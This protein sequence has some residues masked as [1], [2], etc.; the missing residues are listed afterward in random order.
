[1]KKD[2]TEKDVEAI[3]DGI[4]K[5]RV[6]VL[7]KHDA[8]RKKNK[9]KLSIEEV[10]LWESEKLLIKSQKKMLQNQERFNKTTKEYQDQLWEFIQSW[11]KF[12]QAKRRKKA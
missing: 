7:K 11:V 8:L 1:M 6:S 4:R 5:R 12:N 3:L 9:E 10:A 2:L